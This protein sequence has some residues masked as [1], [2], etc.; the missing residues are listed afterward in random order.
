MIEPGRPTSVDSPPMSP[1]APNVL[2]I[3]ADQFRFDCFGAAGNPEVRTPHLDRLAA[4]AVRYPLT[5]CPLPVCTP[6]RY[7]LLSGYYVH[8]H[9]GWTNRSTLPAAV[10]TFPKA[11]RRAGFRTAAVGKMHFTPTYL[12]LGYDRM[13]L[14]EQDGPGRYDD[15]YHGDLMSAGLAPVVDL[16]DQEKE[17][18]PRGSEEYWANYGAV[19]SDLP[20]ERHS[21]TWIGGHALDV[22]EGWSP[23]GGQLL[24]VSFVKPHHP[25]DPPAPWHRAYDPDALSP[26]PGWTGEIPDAD[27]PYKE[28]YFRYDTL[29]LPVLQRVMAYYYATISQ[30]DEWI[31]RMLDLL[32]SRGLYDDTLIVFTSDHGE[33][34]GFHHL[35]LKSGPMYDPLVK[36]PLLVKYPGKSDGTADSRLVSLVDIAPTVLSACGIGSSAQLPGIDLAD[37]RQSRD[38]V[39]AETHPEGSAYMVRTASHKLLT[40]EHPALFDLSADPLELDNRIEDPAQAG[41]VAELGRVLQDWNRQEIRVPD[42]QVRQARKDYFAERL[43]E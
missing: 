37:H 11:L 5:F 1:A 26:L 16:I 27:R 36:V 34:L 6:S 19:R 42:P 32:R 41:R 21:T 40:G 31:G 23:G 18:R 9:G 33:Y 24:H 4:D 2:L 25:F 17:Y 28:R 15:D 29:T 38:H 7:S 20:E 22:L 10:D 30:L 35:L 8:Q 12:D 13:E 39:C 43:R 14:A 3:Q